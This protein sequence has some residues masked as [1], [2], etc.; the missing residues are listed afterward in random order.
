VETP[1]WAYQESEN[2]LIVGYSRVHAIAFDA[3][4]VHP[5]WR[6]PVTPE[7]QQP[8]THGLLARANAALG[9]PALSR[10]VPGRG[11]NQGNFWLR[12]ASGRLWA[13]HDQ[14]AW[15]PIGRFSQVPLGADFDP[16]T[17]QLTV[18]TKAL[19]KLD[20]PGSAQ[21]ESSRLRPLEAE[22][23]HPGSAA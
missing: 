3:Q 1:D 6:G 13:S 22:R 14:F 4:S 21:F 7:M 18:W 12:Y 17:R 23:F 11:P 8:S 10:L 2:R 5:R 15:L 16:A 19:P 20:G 9:L